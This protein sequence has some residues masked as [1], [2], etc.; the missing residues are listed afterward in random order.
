MIF[1][2]TKDDE[3]ETVRICVDG[4]QRLTSIQKFLDGLVSAS[5]CFHATSI[6][7][8]YY[9]SVNRYLVSMIFDVI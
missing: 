8:L 2:V 6:G 7:I 1:A 5:L 9:A 4:K 3:G